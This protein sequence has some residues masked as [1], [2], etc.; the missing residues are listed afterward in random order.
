MEPI[1]CYVCGKLFIKAL[2][3]IFKATV[4]G[5]VKHFCGWNCLRALEKEKEAEKNSKEVKDNV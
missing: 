5:H 1:K 4:N 2:C 3:N